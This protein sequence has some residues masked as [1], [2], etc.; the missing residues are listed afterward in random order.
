MK[1]NEEVIRKK[2]FEKFFEEAEYEPRELYGFLER[3]AA[4]ATLNRKTGAVFFKRNLTQLE[5][6][7]LTAIARFLGYQVD[8]GVNRV[9]SIDEVVKYTTLDT[10]VA[11][12]RIIDL[13][14]AGILLRV[15][16]GLYQARSIAAVRAFIE[17]LDKKYQTE[18][19]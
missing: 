1:E 9:I 5:K 15:G 10:P 7:A 16:T 3:C 19:E 12:R 6:V 14:E 8:E 17:K 11:R 18:E 4:F 2:A 13:V